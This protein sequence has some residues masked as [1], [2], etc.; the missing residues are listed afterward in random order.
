MRARIENENGPRVGWRKAERMNPPLWVGEDI[1]VYV[2]S[3][4]CGNGA[5]RG[6]VMIRFRH[7]GRMGGRTGVG[8]IVRRERAGDERVG[9]VRKGEGAWT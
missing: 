5:F 3:C 4:L 6:L 9:R 7:S 2:I 1:Y 8:Y